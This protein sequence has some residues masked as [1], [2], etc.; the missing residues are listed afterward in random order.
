MAQLKLFSLLERWVPS[1]LAVSQSLG[2]VPLLGRLLKRLV[3]VADYTGI[4][5]LTDQQLR[6]RA[7]L[8]T[9]DMLAPAYDNPQ[10]VATVLRWFDE[11]KLMDVQVGHWGHLVG[12]GT[13]LE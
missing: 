1:L 2:R 4:Y 3:P 5:P 13:K 9:F 11:A 8:D 6:E 10:S 7:L 12:R